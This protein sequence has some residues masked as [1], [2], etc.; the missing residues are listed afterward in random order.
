MAGIPPLEAGTAAVTATGSSDGRGPYI[1]DVRS[2]EEFAAGHVPGAVNLPVDE[3]MARYQEL[4]AVRSN[5]RSI[6]LY[7]AG[8][9]RS[10]YARLILNQLGVPGVENGG[11][12]QDMMRRYG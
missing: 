3:I 4:A 9:S 5:G 10:E 6:V 2:P 8:G 12:Y 1:V 11:G 7:C